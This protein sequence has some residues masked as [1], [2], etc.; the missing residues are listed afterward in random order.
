M[1]DPH[2]GR[3]DD[4]RH[5]P[6]EVVIPER[7]GPTLFQAPEISRRVAAVVEAFQALRDRRPLPDSAG[8]VTPTDRRVPAVPPAD[9]PPLPRRATG[10]G[11]VRP[12]GRAGNPASW[13]ADGARD[14]APTADERWLR[15]SVAAPETED[16]VP[17][18]AA[19]PGANGSRVPGAG[20]PS[21]ADRE[22]P[23][24]ADPVA[25]ALRPAERDAP[26]RPLDGVLLD[27][28]AMAVAVGAFVA[29]WAWLVIVAA[30]TAAGVVAAAREHDR[31]TLQVLWRR[32]G[33]RVAGWL[34][35]RSMVWLPVLAARVVLVSVLLPFAFGAGRWLVEHGA[36]GAVAAGRAAAWHHGFRVAA[37]GAC[38]L[39]V[40]G[41]GAARERRI[42]ALRRRLQPV[43]T[44]GV[45][46]LVVVAVALVVSVPM[47]GPRISESGLAGA[48]GLA[49]LPPFLRD[50][51]DRVRDS[52]VRTELNAATVCLS[53][54]QD[55]R[56]QATYTSGNSAEDPDVATLRTERVVPAPGEV[57]TAIVAVHNQLA[58]WVEQIVV[59][60]DDTSVARIERQTL[61]TAAP[62]VDVP[63]GAATAGYDLL[64][65]GVPGFDRGVAL[66]C[67]AGFV[68]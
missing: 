24:P 17:P 65:D 61:S 48:D 21:A 38:F 25:P 12:I 6:D 58:P 31:P 9:P 43:G 56:W 63:L 41:S 29:P 51:A 55:A 10:A 33:R 8:S 67:S 53:E 28:A 4:S 50:N 37:A 30:A 45:E 5:V 54:R 13:R 16:R 15:S 64:R 68:L 7:P 18:L 22:R 49:W 3:A 40:A 2:Q 62:V 19:S 32:A 47:V 46:T 36:D 27:L 1:G 66:R 52:V 39:L 11:A 35:P 57:A 59:V 26:V 20:E 60:A 14:P 42:V 23:D 44:A 34:R